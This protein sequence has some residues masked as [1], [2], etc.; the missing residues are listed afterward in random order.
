M[1]VASSPHRELVDTFGRLWRHPRATRREVADFQARKLRLLVDHAYRHSPYYRRVFDAAGIRPASIR[2]PG[3]LCLL[4]VTSSPELRRLPA[5]DLVDPRLNA[6]RLVT[7]RTSGSSGRPFT[8]RRGYWE[9]HLMN[10]FR[11]RALRQYGLRVPDRMAVL[12]IRS[13]EH[14][15]I[16]LIFIIIR[17]RLLIYLFGL[18]RLETGT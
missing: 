2:H 5:E 7:R 9:E 10:M 6:G 11:I 13:E 12:G 4:P 17:S 14:T 18:G 8:I 15:M 1:K 16:L 3:D